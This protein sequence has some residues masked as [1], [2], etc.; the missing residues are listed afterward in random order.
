MSKIAIK[1]SEIFT[2][3]EKEGI[4]EEIIGPDAVIH[5][6]ASIENYR[7]I[8]LV[9]LWKEK[10][11]PRVKKKRPVAIVVTR[12]IAES[13]REDSSITLI[14]SSNVY[15]ALA[16]IKQKYVDRD[17]S[18]QGYPRIHPSAV[19]HDT[20]SVPESSSVGPLVVIGRDVQ[21]GE[22]VTILASAVIEH[23]VNIGDDSVI[24]SHTCI[25]HG[26]VIGKQVI[27]RA[28]AN[29]GS[30]GFGFA[31]DARRKNHRIPQT[32]RV[33]IGNRVVIGPLNN[34]DRASYEDT[35]IE[36]GVISD[37]LCHVGHNSVIGEDSIIIA[38]SGVAGSVKVGKRVI[39]GGRTAIQNDIEIADDVVFVH[40]AGIVKD[41]KEA[42]VY[43][44]TPLQPVQKL[45]R[46]KVVL[47]HLDELKKRVIAL[48]KKLKEKE[49]NMGDSR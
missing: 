25:A 19:I 14:V 18:K 11:I 24:H 23:D 10:F 47:A 12:K 16:L 35:H 21:I 20:V 33:V 37:S 30:E 8:D 40:L 39:M 27:I 13:F 36:D 43:G 6:F 28:G 32:G 45:L 41:V 17:F 48:E 9:F 34:I 5:G 4:L 22:R 49:E 3:F 2:E 38:Q 31:Q 26:C 46:N 44:G 29:I 1:V 42:G 7:P 15:L